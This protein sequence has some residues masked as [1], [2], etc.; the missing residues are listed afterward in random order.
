MRSYAELFA[1]AAARKGGPEAL[2]ALLPKAESAE[3][4]AKVPDDRWLA[5]ATKCV[6]NAGFNWKVTEAMWPGFE[7]AF[8]GFQP[9]RWAMMSDD[10]LDRLI[11]D[12]RV[13][14]HGA[15]LQ[16]VRDNAILL[17]E[18]AKEHGSAAKAL[19]QWPST[20]YI[21]L[22]DLLKRRGSRLGGNTGQ[23]FLRFMGK[24]SF[25]ISRDVGAALVRE[26]VVE[27][28]PSS[29]RDFAATQ[30]A[31]N[32]WMAESGRGLTQISRT[33]AMSVGA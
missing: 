20:D 27:K 23:Y 33:L 14:R 22:L 21:G 2:E 30:Q 24:D 6:F 25:I 1:M 26:G 11:A 32:A 28:P 17:R 9:A 7:A 10:D 13:I 5:M 15:K 19:A 18:L 16:S 3:V 12:K 8:E 29:K 4:L 31:F